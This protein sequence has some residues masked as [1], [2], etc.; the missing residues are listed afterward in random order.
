MESYFLHTTGSDTLVISFACYYEIKN[1]NETPYDWKFLKRKR[2]DLDVLYIKDNQM[3]WYLK[4]VEGVSVDIESTLE[5]LKGFIDKY[6][7]IVMIGSSMGGYASLLF[8]YLLNCG[9]IVVAFSP[10]VDLDNSPNQWTK[11]AVDE[12]EDV[13]SSSKKFMSLQNVI[14][15]PLKGVVYYGKDHFC[16]GDQYNLLRKFIGGVGIDTNDHAV[17]RYMMNKQVLDKDLKRY[18]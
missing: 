14:D 11:K 13:P 17:A 18:F 16:D 12:L 7:K 2:K 3:A 8:G 1:G 10:Q 15:R 5:F 9:V 6:K 4:G